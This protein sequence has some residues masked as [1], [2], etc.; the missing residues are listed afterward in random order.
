MNLVY[1][2]HTFDKIL[3][4]TLSLALLVCAIIFYI[5]R[6]T[7]SDTPIYI[8]EMIQKDKLWVATNRYISIFSQILPYIG[9]Q[10]GAGLNVILLLYSINLILIPISLSLISLW[11]FKDYK[12]SIA[13]L[14]FYT[15]I[16]NFLFYYPVSEFQMGLT[17]LLFYHAYF[18]YNK[19][20]KI[21]F[22]FVI[23]NIILIPTIIFSHPLSLVAFL[24]WLSFYVL[25]N[26]DFKNKRLLL[27]ITL[28][29]IAFT[30]K[31]IFFATIVED[32]N[33]DVEKTNLLLKFDGDIAHALSNN[34]SVNFINYW[35]AH[36]FI[37]FF[38]FALVVAFY[39]KR[40]QF[41][42][43]FLFLACVLGSWSM[44]TIAFNNLSYE[45][46][47]E[48]MYQLVNFTLCLHLIH[49]L[50]DGIKYNKIINFIIIVA[51]IFSISKIV[52][53]KAFLQK[54]INWYQQYFEVMRNNN[55]KKAIISPENKNHSLYTHDWASYYETALLSSLNNKDSAA[56][57]IFANDSRRISNINKHPEYFNQQYFNIV[58]TT[59]Y[60]NLDSLSLTDLTGGTIFTN[61]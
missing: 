36:Y 3:A 46:Y 23:T 57:I 30:I 6:T 24:I 54:R 29:I 4:Y 58:D 59:L 32:Q 38:I 14:L 18:T 22:S 21:N 60:Y 13:I 5:E 44:V 33:Y 42:N 34:L 28:A 2:Q 53:N 35:K 41:I 39:I 7:Y 50:K 45:H 52:S 16:N 27:P 48:H 37:L 8:F 9:L 1:K 10:L 56:I 40:K 51:C 15:L 17:C 26:K 55:I 49:I 19:E 12:S 20:H 31:T 61:K 43:L 25:S 47:T 11:K